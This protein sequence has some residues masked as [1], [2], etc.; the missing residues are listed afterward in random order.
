MQEK[1]EIGIYTVQWS[2]Q[3]WFWVMGDGDNIDL[4][5]HKFHTRIECIWISICIH[6][7]KISPISHHY[8]NEWWDKLGIVIHSL[9]WTPQAWFWVMGEDNFGSSVLPTVSY[10]DWVC[11]DQHRKI[12][13]AGVVHCHIIKIINGA[14]TSLCTFNLGVKHRDIWSRNFQTPVTRKWGCGDG[15]GR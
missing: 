5:S 3:D 2:P 10:Q 11:L 14:R 15:F 7:S 1:V 4:S 9:Q 8:Y 6:S 13:A 12:I